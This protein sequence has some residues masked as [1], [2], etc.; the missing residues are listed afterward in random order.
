MLTDCGFWRGE[1]LCCFSWDR[2]KRLFTP[3]R[4]PMTQQT[5]GSTQ[6]EFGEPM[7]LLGLLMGSWMRGHLQEPD[8]GLQESM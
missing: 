5:K 1:I 3:D 6:V 8:E 2:N 4:A 7:S